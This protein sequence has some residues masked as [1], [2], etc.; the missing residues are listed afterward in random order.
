MS[1]KCFNDHDR[2]CYIC[3]KVNLKERRANITD[4]VIK[5]YH[6]YFGIILGDENNIFA[7]HI[8][9]KTPVDNLQNWNT[10]K[11]ES[12]P[13]GVSMIWQVAKNHLTNCYFCK[14]NLQGT[15]F[16]FINVLSY[17]VTMVTKTVGKYMYIASY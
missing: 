13:F 16:I 10:R 4:F 3:G 6:A 14:T 5:A 11:K 1:R 7:P 12:L 17:I 8:S 9:C 15:A 2:F